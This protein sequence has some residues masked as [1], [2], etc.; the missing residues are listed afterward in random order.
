MAYK[1][2]N[3]A[4]VDM[5]EQTFEEIKDDDLEATVARAGLLPTGLAEPTAQDA[6]GGRGEAA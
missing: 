3:P 6:R 2:T 1:S 4:T 5:V